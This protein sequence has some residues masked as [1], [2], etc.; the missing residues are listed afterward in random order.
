MTPSDKLPV[1]ELK[2]WSEN[3]P[4]TVHLDK[5]DGDQF[6]CPDPS[7]QKFVR[8]SFAMETIYRF[9]D[10]QV[11]LDFVKALAADPLV[12]GAQWISNKPVAPPIE[13]EDGR[14]Y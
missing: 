3:V 13:S 2:M 7:W 4:V 14:I 12:K 8:N 5:A 10:E 6:T 1:F 11:V 9:S